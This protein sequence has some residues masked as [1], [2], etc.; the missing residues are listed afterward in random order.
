MRKLIKRST[1]PV[2][3]VVL[4]MLGVGSSMSAE[5]PAPKFRSDVAPYARSLA[6]KTVVNPHEQVNDE[7]EVLWGVCLVCHKGVPDLSMDRQGDIE[8]RVGGEYKELCYKCHTIKNHPAT[9]DTIGG[10]MSFIYATDHLVE[11]TKIISLNMR[12]ALKEV[13]TILPLDPETGKVTCVTCHNSHEKGV[14]KGRNDW[15]ADSVRRLRSEG[16]EI[17]QY[18]HRK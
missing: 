18:C 6:L 13:N 1:I 8:L 4:L 15:G 11:P 9:K 3:A 7:G 14:L 17:C 5:E 12:L 16:L 10:A 2:L